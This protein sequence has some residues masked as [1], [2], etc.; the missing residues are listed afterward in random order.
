MWET[1]SSPDISFGK[2]V[3]RISANDIFCLSLVKINS[4]MGLQILI[5]ELIACTDGSLTGMEFNIPCV[6][7]G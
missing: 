3:S 6:I 1:S 5:K 4:C 2:S 7:S